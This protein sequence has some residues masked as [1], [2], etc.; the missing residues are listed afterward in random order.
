M[1]LPASRIPPCSNIPTEKSDT[2]VLKIPGQGFDFFAVTTRAVR[3]GERVYAI[4]NPQGLEQ[5]MTD[6]IVSGL[7]NEDA[8]QWIQHSAPISPGSSGGALISSRGEL[9]GINSFLLK[10]SQNLNFA[11]PSATLTQAISGARTLAGLL[12]FPGSTPVSQAEAS[13]G[14]PQAPSRSEPPPPPASS[15]RQNG[16]NLAQQPVRLNVTVLDK[17][18]RLLANVPQSAF[19]VLENGA[20]Q[21]IQIFKWEDVAVSMGVV[22]DNSGNMRDRR[23]SLVS[24]ASALVHN[25]NREDEAFIVNFNDEPYLD[26]DLTNDI[27]VL[28]QGLMKIDTRGLAAIRDAIRASIDHLKDKGKR[29]KKVIIV[30]TGGNDNAS[31]ISPEALVRLA[32][33]N[34]VVINVIGLLSKDGAKDARGVLNLL[35][36]STGGQVVYP[37]DTSEAERVAHEL[38]LDIR[39][40]YTIV[41]SPTNTVADGSFRQIKVLVNGPGSPSAR[42]RKGYY[43]SKDRQ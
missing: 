15:F 9:L 4:G 30:V 28:E 1:R 19:T 31:T 39:T 21:Q 36:E 12:K 16:P 42:T 7:R 35:A 43:A 27:A 23:S 25:S 24:A 40:Q 34:N 37:K 41:Y 18:G 14:A 26:A 5:S 6:G 20:P 11:V 33:Q 2:A 8:T 17:S 10:E 22:I 32:Q 3:V 29:D 13:V 38:A